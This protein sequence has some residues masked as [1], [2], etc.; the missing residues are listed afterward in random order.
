MEENI[1]GKNIKYMRNLYGETGDE[2]GC[3]LKVTKSAIADYESGRRKPDPEILKKI[4]NKY[5]KTVD[6]ML[7]VKLYELE[8]F[9][10]SRI[11]DYV[12]MFEAVSRILPLIESKEA[13]EN[14]NF[15]K[16]M[17]II[18]EMLNMKD[19]DIS[20]GIK[21]FAEASD[22]DI[23]EASAN[24]LYCIFLLWMGQCTDFASQQKFQ[25]RLVSKQVDWKELIYETQKKQKKLV[26]ER[27]VF[28]DNFDVVINILI[29][30]LKRTEQW[31]PLG[32]YY[33]ALRYV[34][35]MINTGE[36]DAMN[37]AVGI[38]MIKSFAQIG[39]KY[40]LDFIDACSTM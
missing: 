28:I 34:L 12:G 29:K 37:Q 21:Y 35:G 18:K 4:C 5:R 32:D 6:E 26:N 20:D 15:S 39:N 40:A 36:S 9:D 19:V 3:T 24:T 38:Q 22:M 14:D 17:T 16:G 23:S 11:V 27:I 25:S 10:S 7:N 1:L 31:A 30:K 33:L 2:L 8:E 13:Y